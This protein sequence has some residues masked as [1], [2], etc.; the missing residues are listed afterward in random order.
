VKE[1]TIEAGAKANHLSYIGNARVGK[2][3]NI[4]AGTITCNYDGVAKHHTDI[5]DGS[6]I[7]SNSSL[8][9]PV[10]IGDGAYV[11]S[12]SVVTDDVPSDALAIARSKQTTKKG[13]AK[14]MRQ[15]NG[16]TKN[17]SKKPGKSKKKSKKRV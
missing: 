14:R 17:L 1:A 10:K 5:G 2:G 12:G 3:A 15:V 7:G 6:F 16:S 4:G 13:W 9:A 8:V 11:G